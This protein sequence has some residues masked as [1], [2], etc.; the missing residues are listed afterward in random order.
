MLLSEYDIRYVSQKGIKESVV[1]EIL[2]LRASED[3][4]PIDFDFFDEDLMAISHDEKESSENTC[5]KLYFD[6]A[7]NALGMISVIF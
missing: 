2:V 3:Y 4:E 6:G 7:F 5:W 1:V